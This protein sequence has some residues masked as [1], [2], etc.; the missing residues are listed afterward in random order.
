MR[1]CLTCFGAIFEPTESA[2]GTGKLCYCHLKDFDDKSWQS[3][4]INPPKLMPYIPNTL[5]LEER[6]NKLESEILI[7]KKLILAVRFEA[8]EKR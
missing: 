3:P 2:N 4:H 7:L 6:I 8:T 1:T 5:E